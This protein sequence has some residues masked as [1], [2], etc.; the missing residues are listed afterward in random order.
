MNDYKFDIFTDSAANLNEEMLARTGIKVIS[1]H[2][3]I[4]GE[5]TVCF[6]E[7]VPFAQTAESFYGKMSAG[8][9]VSTSLVCEARI[10]EAVL[11]SVRAGRDVLFITISSG[12]SGTHSQALAAQESINQSYPDVKFIVADS[13][14]ASL[15]EGL[16]AMGA[17]RLRDMGESIEACAKWIEDNKYKMNAYLTVNDLKYLRKGGRISATLAI[18]GTLL[19]I[20]PVIKA[21]GGSQAKLTFA[22]KERGRRRALDALLR[23]FD[24]NVISPENQTVAV[25]HCNCVQDALYLAEAV[26]QRGVRDVIVEYYDV[27][28]GA[29]VGPG[30]VALFFTGKDRRAQAAA[31]EA[32]K[33]GKTAVRKMSS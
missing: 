6:D 28:T 10:L 1:Y 21:D 8:A 17:A 33:R 20:K 23:A 2:C 9:E 3:L 11:P 24:E 19:N 25:A 13:A 14:I 27:C 15:G 4:N 31:A 5:D 16:L 7:G 12:I 22:G 26:K 30:T 32:Q 18:A 29:H